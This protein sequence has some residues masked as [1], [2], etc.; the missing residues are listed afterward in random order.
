MAMLARGGYSAGGPNQPRR[1]SYASHHQNTIGSAINAKGRRRQ[2][3][4]SRYQVPTESTGLRTPRAYADSAG[5]LGTRQY[6]P[7][8]LEAW[9]TGEQMLR[10]WHAISQSVYATG[11]PCA[12]P[13]LLERYIEGELRFT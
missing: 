12:R 8:S 10:T 13:T 1:N 3:G 5:V 4:R 6:P 2:Y 11:Q 9:L 7:G